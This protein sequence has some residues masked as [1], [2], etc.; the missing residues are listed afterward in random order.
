MFRCSQEVTYKPHFNQPITVAQ[1]NVQT[2]ALID[3][4]LL[5][6]RTIIG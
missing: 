6:R 3:G 2:P 1:F 5:I 4:S